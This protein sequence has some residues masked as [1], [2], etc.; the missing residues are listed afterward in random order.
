M[1]GWTRLVTLSKSV[2]LDINLCAILILNSCYRFLISFVNKFRQISWRCHS[3]TIAL[4]QCMQLK[5][6]AMPR[7]QY[8]HLYRINLELCMPIFSLPIFKLGNFLTCYFTSRLVAIRRYTGYSNLANA[9]LRTNGAWLMLMIPI[10]KNTNRLRW[11]LFLEMPLNLISKTISLVLF[12]SSLCTG[13]NRT[14]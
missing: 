14:R 7:M 13:W 11:S 5:L 1:L 9:L 2:Q 8:V 12:R 10:I 3:L 6:L 4:M